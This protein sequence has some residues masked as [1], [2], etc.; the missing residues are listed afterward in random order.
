MKEPVFISAPS[1]VTGAFVELDRLAL[2]DAE[3][4]S[5]LEVG[6]AGA[7]TLVDIPLMT[8]AAQAMRK[9]M[10]ATMI[11]ADDVDAV[12]LCT[13]SF[14]WHRQLS[15]GSI[16]RALL[17]LGMQR[18]QVVMASVMGC[19]NAITG[20]R[21]ARSLIRSEPLRNVMLV[22][23][24]VAAPDASRLADGPSVLGDGAAACL[25]STQFHG[26]GYQLMDLVL[27]DGHRIARLGD[28]PEDRQLK[29]VEWLSAVK[30]VCAELL[31]RNTLHADQIDRLI[32]NNYNPRMSRWIASQAG[33]DPQRAC[34]FDRTRGHIWSSDILISLAETAGQ[35][36]FE[37]VDRLLCVGSGPHNFGAALLERRA[38]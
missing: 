9:A 10:A 33:V 34:T 31:K 4:S 15:S 17:D 11:R 19:H 21:L 28:C 13:S 20:L 2:D 16:S 27:H 18:A 36:D 37:G 25:V 7:R 32:C 12:V 26:S 35:Q 38:N 24:D 30:G 14:W 3:R 29:L 6:V 22:T 8:L 5:L 1:Y 23:V